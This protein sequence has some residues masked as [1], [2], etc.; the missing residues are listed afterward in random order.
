MRY[1][2]ARDKSTALD[3]KYRMKLNSIR[4][5][6]TLSVNLIEEAYTGEHCGRISFLDLRH[7]VKALQELS[8]SC[9][10]LFF[11]RALT[12]TRR[13]R[14]LC[15]HRCAALIGK[16]DMDVSIFF[17]FVSG[18]LRGHSEHRIFNRRDAISFRKRRRSA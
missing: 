16:D 18:D 17:Q 7:G 8:T 2:G 9:Y 3:C 10:H 15:N 14:Y 1:C 11:P 12:H 6:S 4:R 13:V 5:Y